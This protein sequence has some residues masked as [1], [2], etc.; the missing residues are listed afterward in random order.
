MNSFQDLP[1]TPELMKALK[2]LNFHK[3]TEIQ[4]SVIPLAQ[5][6]KD[7]LACAE[8]GSG[9]TAAY[10]IPMVVRLMN[11]PQK[12]G[13]ILAPTRELAQQITDFVKKLTS[14]HRHFSI[15]CL[16]GGASYHQQNR[17]LKRKPRIIIATPGRL[18]DHLQRKTLQL[19]KAEILV[20]DEAD[21]MLDMGFAPQLHEIL[22]YLPKS[23]QTLLFTAT[24]S[25][26]MAQ[27]AE[28]YLSQPEKINV[29]KK[30]KPVAAIKQSAVKV[31]PKEK[32][33]KLVDEL[34][35]R[36]GSVIVFIKTQRRTDVL[37]KHLSSYGFKVELIHGGRTQG[38]RNRAISNFKTGRVRILC[39][40][41]IAARGIDIPEVAHV[42]NFDL[43]MMSED[44]VHRLGRTARNGA[45]GEAVSFICPEDYRT[46]QTLSKKFE[47]PHSDLGLP[48]KERPPRRATNKK[49]SKKK[50]RT[51]RPK[52]LS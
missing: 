42:I 44:Y 11:C 45:S 7:I 13:L 39:A 27:L 20:L 26:K 29:D 10:A 32:N 48:N 24:L 15:A 33:D 50:F 28:T 46:W 47:I 38:Q 5:I 18:I 23:R 16:V 40:T 2:T 3:P 37:A 25:R 35:Q 14:S 4:K 21:R 19:S 17:D 49:F 30:A 12:A 34:N 52:S 8:T 36:Q 51:R 31:N 1:L 22:K 6:G 9:K 43:P 41:D